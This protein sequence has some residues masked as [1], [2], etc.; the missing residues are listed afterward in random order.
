MEPTEQEHFPGVQPHNPYAALGYRD[1][2]LLLGG[3]LVATLGEQMATVAIGWELYNRT[4]SPLALGLVGLVQVLPIILLS[5]PAGHMADR[6]N[7]KAMILITQAALILGAL[8]LWLISSLGVAVELTYGCLLLIGI[9]RAFNGPAASTL[10]PQTVPPEVYSNATTWSSSAWQLSGVVGPALGGLAIAWAGYAAPVY[11][12]NAGTGLVA[13]VVIMLI[14]SR[15]VPQEA[16]GEHEPALQSLVNGLRFV[17]RTKIILSA[18]VL[19]L[20]AVLLGGATAL[21]PV[22]ARDILHVG[23]DGLGWM[24]AATPVGAMATALLLAY[25]PPLK[26]AGPTLLLAVAG[27]GL[28]TII[29][30]LSRSFPLSLL[31]LALLGAFDMVSVVV[32]HTLVLLHTPDSMRGRVSA[33]NSVFISSSNEL[34][35]FESGVVATL[36]GPVVTVALG[37]IGTLIV[38]LAASRLWPEL[39]RLGRLDAKPETEG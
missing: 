3:E 24:R 22:F 37:G 28:A 13:L 18:I 2:R 1:F 30:G 5:L 11:L 32:R 29:F 21:M 16:R 35:A 6:Y 8:G 31:M 14:R 20:F 34:G 39:T 26:R 10:L 7:R 33:V 12:F 19:D 38:V 9:A 36:L 27:F 23:A 17:W 15:P 4:N 25:M